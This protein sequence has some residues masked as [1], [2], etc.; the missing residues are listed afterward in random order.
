MGTDA[1]LTL[2]RAGTSPG[3]ATWTTGTRPMA[4]GGW[5]VCPSSP[6]AVR[7]TPQGPHHLRGE[8]VREARWPR[9]PS[10][11]KGYAVRHPRVDTRAPTGK[12]LLPSSG[13]REDH[14]AKESRSTRLRR[15]VRLRLIRTD[16]PCRLRPARRPSALVSEISA[17]P[18]LRAGV[19]RRLR[20][21]RAPARW[22]SV[23]SRSAHPLRIPA[24][25]SGICL[26][27]DL[28]K[29]MKIGPGRAVSLSSKS[30]P[31]RLRSRPRRSPEG[32]GSTISA[33]LRGATGAGEPE[34]AAVCRVTC[35]RQ[36]FVP[37]SR[38]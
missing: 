31:R 13:R 18:V 12:G 14:A 32:R 11:P 28:G 8:A 23:R 30:L 21:R 24:I 27:D 9:S 29:S 38:S 3:S 17:S 6:M 10:W 7:E 34:Q 25:G 4:G 5:I 36:A 2:E 15:L 20:L 33:A 16:S 37:G 1:G 35:F 22:S 26:R 19:R